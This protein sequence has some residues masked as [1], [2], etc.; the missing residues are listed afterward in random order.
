MD[1]SRERETGECA[2]FL[3]RS[4]GAGAG[5][6]FRISHG[7]EM[8]DWAARASPF[9][10]MGGH[11]FVWSLRIDG[12]A[13]GAGEVYGEPQWD[14]SSGALESGAWEA[15]ARGAL[16]CFRSDSRVRPH[17]QTTTQKYG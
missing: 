17:T 3:I 5:E 6:M 2:M 4:P 12:V 14:G 10:R 16:G 11:G 7:R 13:W 15:R 9:L 1:G 8:T